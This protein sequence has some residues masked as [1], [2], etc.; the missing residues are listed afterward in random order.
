MPT[1]H[2]RLF[3][4]RDTACYEIS[5]TDKET[6]WCMRTAWSDYQDAGPP[7]CIVIYLQGGE[8]SHPTPGPWRELAGELI[9]IIKR[10]V[11]SGG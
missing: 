5:T 10:W 2:A 9:V 4:S 1:T 3:V 7:M 11:E 6:F 8:W